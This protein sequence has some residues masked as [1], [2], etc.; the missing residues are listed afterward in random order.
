MNRNTMKVC[1]ACVCLCLT[2]MEGCALPGTPAAPIAAPGLPAGVT[3]SVVAVAVPTPP[4]M[5]LPQF[6]GL[7]SLGRGV[8]V[9]TRQLRLKLASR[10][11]ALQPS[12]SNPP[13]A[14]GDP[15]NLQS[16]SPAVATAAAAQ[17]AAADAPAKAAALAYLATLG[18]RQQPGAEE[19]FLA[20]LDDVSAEVRAAAAQAVIDS[21]K[22]AGSLKCDCQCSC[23]GCC[24]QAIRMKLMHLAYEQATPGCY[25]EPDS[26]V[27]RLCRLALA[28]CGK[29]EVGVLAE[30]E[31][32]P[33]PASIQAIHVSAAKS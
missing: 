10:W 13:R 2:G 14:I 32:T 17:Q 25:C 12:V 19:A 26:K 31:E 15:A 27:R 4:P 23:S 18:C 24:T 28:A 16:P 20:G 6:L 1:L 33:P 21:Q 9:G 3:P 5:T 11:P 30:P 8:I 22:T 29:S 7:D